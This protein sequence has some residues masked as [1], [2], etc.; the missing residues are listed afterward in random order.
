MNSPRIS[1]TKNRAP[2]RRKTRP[3]HR[4][5]YGRCGRPGE[6]RKACSMICLPGQQSTPGSNSAHRLPTAPVRQGLG[7]PWRTSVSQR[8][9]RT[10]R[11]RAMAN[12]VE[13]LAAPHRFLKKMHKREIKGGDADGPS[14]TAA[15]A[16]HYGDDHQ[17][18]NAR[19]EQRADELECGGQNRLAQQCAACVICKHRLPHS[20][21]R[22]TSGWRSRLWA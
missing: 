7:S 22:W 1:L 4:R 17:H 19:E 6:V 5:D 15:A 21:T 16:S 3:S 11:I 10:I 2:L 9:K 12:S 18:V 14:L 20:M 13:Q 8:S